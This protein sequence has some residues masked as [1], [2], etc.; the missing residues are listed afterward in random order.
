MKHLY[1]DIV[2]RMLVLFW[3]GFFGKENRLKIFGPQTTTS[4]SESFVLPCP[5]R[6]QG[7]H[8][9]AADTPVDLLSPEN[10]LGP[11][12]IWTYP[13][14]DAI[15]ELRE[16]SR[17]LKF[18]VASQILCVASP[19]FCDMPGPHT[20]FKIACDLRRTFGS[21]GEPWTLVTWGGDPHALAVLLNVLH[22]RSEKVPRTV[23]FDELWELAVL[24]D[25]YG[26]VS[27]MEPWIAMWT[28]KLPQ[29]RDN[30]SECLVKWLSMARVF[31][32]DDL[33]EKVTR[34]IILEGRYFGRIPADDHLAMP[35]YVRLS[36][37]RFLIPRPVICKPISSIGSP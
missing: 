11:N 31:G 24:C 35:S 25:K 17:S 1:Y 29:H 2:I 5:T 16:D 9:R 19:Y 13:E 34:E 22:F 12:P 8:E 6:T 30:F 4:N 3:I 10:L 33:F 23:S 28:R 14:G 36:D 37:P 27:A 32:R 18:R 21:K 26:C 15:L 7:A 20:T